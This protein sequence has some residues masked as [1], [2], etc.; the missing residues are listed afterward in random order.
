MRAPSIRSFIRFR[1]RRNV[2]LPQPDG[3]ISAVISFFRI[4]RLMSR[5]ARNVAV[6]HGEIGDAEHH[7]ADGLVGLGDG[8]EGFTISWGPSSVTEATG[9]VMSVSI[10]RFTT[11]G[12]SGSSAGSPRGSRRG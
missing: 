4:G 12:H 6:V 5:T 8:A 7:L 1:Q 11:F 2:V 9:V 3:P 10:H